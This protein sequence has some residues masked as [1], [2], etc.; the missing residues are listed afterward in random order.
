[1]HRGNCLTAGKRGA[2]SGQTVMPE[3]IRMKGQQHNAAPRLQ[4]PTAK[5]NHTLSAH[6]LVQSLTSGTYE[7]NKQHSL[8]ALDEPPT[9]LVVDAIANR[10]SYTVVPA[11]VKEKRMCATSEIGGV[12]CLC[13]G[14]RSNRRLATTLKCLYTQVLP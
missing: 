4:A 9:Q 14:Y 6:M 7:A 10:Q 12:G 1:M 2:G 11:R 13:S 3:A 8:A 5:R